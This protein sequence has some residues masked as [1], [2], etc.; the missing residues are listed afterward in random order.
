MSEQEIKPVALSTEYIG[1]DRYLGDESHLIA[2]NTG[3][4]LGLQGDHRLLS[5]NLDNQRIVIYE[6]VSGTD[7]YPPG[8]NMRVEISGQE[9][10][11]MIKIYQDRLMRAEELQAKWRAAHPAAAAASDDFD[12]F[13][14]DLP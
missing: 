7:R 6:A 9:F 14:D 1:D 13:L 3:A 12:P 10:E 2:S 11:A 4:S 5:M 8:R